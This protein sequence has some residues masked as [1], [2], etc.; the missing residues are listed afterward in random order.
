MGKSQEL[1][2]ALPP[3]SESLA[4][5]AG[6]APSSM[7][8]TWSHEALVHQRLTS[9]NWD[10]LW[11]LKKKKVGFQMLNANKRPWNISLIFKFTCLHIEMIFRWIRLNEVYL[12][13]HV[14]VLVL[15]MGLIWHF[16]WIALH[17]TLP[18][19]TFL[20]AVVFNSSS[21]ILGFWGL[22]GRASLME[23]PSLSP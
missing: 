19:T 5:S 10:M 23:R 16:H 1:G 14:F 9:P 8:A 7:V 20:P 3:A 13:L 12:K 6:P 18:S 15:W 22:G 4:V 2:P 21:H 11:V 17:Y